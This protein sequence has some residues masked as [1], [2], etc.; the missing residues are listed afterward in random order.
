MGLISKDLFGRISINSIDE[1]EAR[2]LLTAL[3]EAISIKRSSGSPLSAI[4]VKIAHEL[5]EKL[6]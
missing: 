4:V 1:Q 6:K 5:G 3:R 2:E